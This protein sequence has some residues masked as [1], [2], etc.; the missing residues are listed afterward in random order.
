MVENPRPGSP[1]RISYAR[2]I[3]HCRTGIA[4]FTR[5]GALKFR[6]LQPSSRS[7]SDVY[8]DHRGMIWWNGNDPG[9]MHRPGEIVS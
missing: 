1:H 4:Y 2:A 8:V 9:G 7:A 6:T 5:D 3:E